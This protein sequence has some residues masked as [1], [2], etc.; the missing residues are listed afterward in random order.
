MPR[1]NLSDQFDAQQRKEYRPKIVARNTFRFER[2]GETVIRL[3]GTDIVTKH[4]NGSV[5]LHDGGWKT[6]TTKDRINRYMPAGY[7]LYQE[8]GAWYVMRHDSKGV[9]WNGTRV[10]YFDGIRVP[11]CFSKMNGKGAA[12]E[13][14]EKTL[15]VQIRKFV[16]KLDKLSELPAPSQGDCWICCMHDKNGKS[17]GELSGDKSHIFEHVKEGYL[18]GSLILNALKW[19][20]YRSP[21]VI[22]GMTNLDMKEGR[23]SKADMVKRALKRY[24]YRQCGLVS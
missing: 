22:W 15:R 3:H 13:K 24:L 23:A 4:K 14:K 17:W 7:S 5:T 10:P 16:A 12:T 11:Q 6:V 21:E 8:S 2:D 9:W 18:H 19:A 1:T 20:G